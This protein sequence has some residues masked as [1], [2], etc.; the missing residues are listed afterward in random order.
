MVLGLEVSIVQMSILE[1]WELEQLVPSR[2]AYFI[3]KHD[4]PFI[5]EF[6]QVATFCS[7]FIWRRSMHRGFG[8]MTEDIDA[9]LTSVGLLKWIF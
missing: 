3:G 9:I 8:M 6:M 7:P 1:Y 4:V 2:V 5:L